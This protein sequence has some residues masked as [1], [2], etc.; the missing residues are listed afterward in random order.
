MDLIDLKVEF[1]KEKKRKKK[2]KERK[3]KN[4]RKEYSGKIEQKVQID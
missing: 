1:I 3:G 2:R 4:S